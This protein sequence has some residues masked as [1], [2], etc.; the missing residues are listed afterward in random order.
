LQL[1]SLHLQQRQS[2]HWHCAHVQHAQ[3]LLSVEAVFMAISL[4]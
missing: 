2:V 1:Q 3:V 4:V